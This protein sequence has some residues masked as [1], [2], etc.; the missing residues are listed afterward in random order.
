LKNKKLLSPRNKD[1]NNLQLQILNH[2]MQDLTTECNNKNNELKAV[3]T[4]KDKL[5]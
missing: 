1:D 4:Q 5:E 3:T 2:K